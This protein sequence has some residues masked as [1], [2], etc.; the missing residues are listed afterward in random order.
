MLSLKCSCKGALH[1]EYL[2]GNIN[3]DGN[4]YIIVNSPKLVCSKCNKIYWAYGVKEICEKIIDNCFSEEKDKG[5]TFYLDFDKI[6]NRFCIDKFISTNVKF[7]YDRDDYYFLPGLI[8]EFNKGFLTPIFFNIEVLLKY[9]HHPKYS[10]DLGANTYG[11]IYMNDEHMIPFGINENNKIIMWLGDIRALSVEEQFYLRSENVLSDHSISS[12]F[13][14]AQIDVVWAE[15]STIKQVFKK[16]LDFNE[17][18]TKHYKIRVAQ[19]DTETVQLA[20][21][22]YRPIV[23]TEEEFS[24]II[25]AMNKLFVEA[26]CEKEI[27]SF[28]KQN[29]SDIDLKNKRGLKV[30]QN[31]L[32][33]Y[34]DNIDIN[35]VI[36]PLYVL[37]DLRVAMAHLQ[38]NETKERMLKSCCERLGLDENERDYIKIF[39][40]LINKLNEMYDLFSDNLRLNNNEGEEQ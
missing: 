20:S 35:D 17:K 11:Q 21:N 25:I 23:N 12:E 26:I 5:E 40:I 13:Y 10:V 28:L 19:L 33:L 14:E 27:K 8:R 16:R 22:I 38:S 24:S 32:D 37:Y 18:I 34:V 3:R 39:D 2:Y 1:L 31:W 30:Y 29:H 36:C 15:P 6:K 4:K 9:M 7:L